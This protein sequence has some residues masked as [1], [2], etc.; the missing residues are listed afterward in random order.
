MAT[1]TT[2]TG[3][4]TTSGANTYSRGK[5]SINTVWLLMLVGCV[6]IFGFFNSYHNLKSYDYYYKDPAYYYSSAS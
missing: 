5:N 1:T 2:A 3:M 6:T 4:A